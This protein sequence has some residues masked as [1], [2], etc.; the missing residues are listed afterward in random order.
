MYS[1]NIV[2]QPTFIE[3]LLT[4][5][6]G[7]NKFLYFQGGY[8][9]PGSVS[10]NSYLI[11]VC[12]SDFQLSYPMTCH[13]KFKI[14]STELGQL[15]SLCFWGKRG[16]EEGESIFLALFLFMSKW[17]IYTIITQRIKS[18]AVLL[19]GLVQQNCI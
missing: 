17:E 3:H 2:I 1:L 14:H 10:I 7:N 5:G 8:W 11:R 16:G 4:L 6:A 9:Q 12:F 18:Q 13:Q 19:K 15:M